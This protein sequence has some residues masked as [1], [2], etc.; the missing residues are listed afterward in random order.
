MHLQ[1]YI[2]MNIHQ[3]FESGTLLQASYSFLVSSSHTLHFELLKPMPHDYI[4]NIYQN[5]A[6][7]LS[8]PPPK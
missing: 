1:Q 6:F 4:S 2:T 5:V 8:P 3:K 7:L